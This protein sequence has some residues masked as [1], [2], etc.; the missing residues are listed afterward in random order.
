MN[1]FPIHILLPLN[2]YNKKKYN[3]SFIQ[4]IKKNIII[5]ILNFP[6]EGLFPDNVKRISKTSTLRYPNY[7]L[8]FVIVFLNL[9]S[10]SWK[11]ENGF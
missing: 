1:T 7:F 2:K 5:Y 6:N 8:K 10:K 4:Y 3:A 9:F 11:D